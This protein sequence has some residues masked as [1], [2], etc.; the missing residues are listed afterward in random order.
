VVIDISRGKPKN[1]ANEFRVKHAIWR[2]F[3]SLKATLILPLK[4]YCFPLRLTINTLGFIERD[5]LTADAGM[6]N[7]ALNRVLPNPYARLAVFGQKP[8][9]T[10]HPFNCLT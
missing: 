8:Q 1:S 10:K 9:S 5:S 7:K 2:S 3:K 6:K 4:G